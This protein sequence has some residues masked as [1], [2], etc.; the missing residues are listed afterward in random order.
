MPKDA[1]I[2]ARVD[3]ALK[4]KAEKVLRQV[5]VTTTD[6][7]TMLLHQIVL[8]KGLPFDVRVPTKETRKA[9]AEARGGKGTTHT[10]STKSALQE[11]TETD[12]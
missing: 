3:S 1:Y 7:V 10:G 5:G 9:I 2:N 8:Q 11:I 6:A 12:D 4:G